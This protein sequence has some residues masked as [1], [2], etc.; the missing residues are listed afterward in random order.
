MPF[1]LETEHLATKFLF[2]V[3]F[4]DRHHMPEPIIAEAL[5]MRGSSATRSC[6][7]NP[8]LKSKL[9]DVYVYPDELLFFD[10]TV[11]RAFE[12]ALV[13]KRKGGGFF[14][15]CFVVVH[16]VFDFESAFCKMV[17]VSIDVLKDGMESM[18]S[19]ITLIYFL[20]AYLASSTLQS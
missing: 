20:V 12:V 13:H 6:Q 2:R 9:L 16:A 4:G 18:V 5:G 11:L 10:F 19:N 14:T 15:C 8:V 1:I 3:Q 17:V 7:P